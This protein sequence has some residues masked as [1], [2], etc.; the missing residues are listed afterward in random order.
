MK[1]LIEENKHIRRA[2]DLEDQPSRSRPFLSM[3]RKHLKLLGEENKHTNRA[4]DP[5]DQLINSGLSLSKKRKTF[6][7]PG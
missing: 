6:G 2:F 4:L 7:D 3:R 5:K 1:I